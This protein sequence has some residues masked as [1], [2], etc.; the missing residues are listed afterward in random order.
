MAIINLLVTL[1]QVNASGSVVA[2][3]AGAFV[4][5]DLAARAGEAGRAEAFGSVVDSNAEASVFAETIG[6]DDILAIVLG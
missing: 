4:D 1:R 2:G 5:V 6:A 3:G